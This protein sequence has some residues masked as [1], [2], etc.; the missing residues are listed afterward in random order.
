KFR[1]SLR[2]SPY[3]FG[4]IFTKLASDSVFT[5]NNSQNQQIPL[6]DQLAVALYRFGHGGHGA[7]M[8]TV[9]N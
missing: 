6:A 4:Q 8:Q 3:T 9:T 5:N 1:E 2:V 7:S